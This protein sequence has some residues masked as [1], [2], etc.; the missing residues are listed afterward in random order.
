MKRDEAIQKSEQAL[1]ELALA[2]EEGRSDTLV[3]YLDMLARFHRYSFGNCMLIAMQRPEATLV[4]GFNRWKKLGRKVKKGEC[5]IG[6][7]APVV[8]RAEVRKDSD[9][10][11]EEKLT[12]LTSL[13]GFKVVHVFDV[14]QTEGK[15]VAEFACITGDPGEQLAR[16]E[17][18]VRAK[19]IELAY[20]PIPG[21]ALGMSEG[22]KITIVPTLGPAETFSLLAH[23]LGHELLHRTE[24]RKET[25]KT[26]RETEAEAVAYVVCRAAG[27]D[28]STRSSDY[29]QLYSG[30][31]DTL[32]ESL[33]HIQRVASSVIAELETM[34]EDQDSQAA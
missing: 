4:A 20:A 22:G 11:L 3:R 30:D 24:R 10:A 28:C 33:D 12:R 5:G 7:L 9:D 15:P 13:C 18:I 21:G 23:E 25:S 34:P 17:G 19:N 29:I 27:L 8:Y 1:E 6:I 26:V 16:L 31:K 2:L 14:K 32:Q